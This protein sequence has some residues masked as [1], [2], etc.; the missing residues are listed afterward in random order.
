MALRPGFRNPS[1]VKA[2]EPDALI[3][4][5]S[6]VKYLL[7]QVSRMERGERME[8]PSPVEGRITQ[9]Q[10]CYFHLRHAESHLSFQIAA[11]STA[12]ER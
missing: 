11:G 6:G 8:Q 5:G 2:V 12:Q 3:P 7:E 9:E 1:S 4:D 10:W